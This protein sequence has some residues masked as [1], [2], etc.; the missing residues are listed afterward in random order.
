MVAQ[1]MPVDHRAMP[2]APPVSFVPTGPRRPVP[3][4]PWRFAPCL[5]VALVLPLLFFGVAHLAVQAVPRND[6][7]FEQACSASGFGGLLVFACVGVVAEL[8]AIVAF[9]VSFGRSNSARLASRIM[10]GIAVASLIPAGV[11]LH[12]G[13]RASYINSD[14]H[15]AHEC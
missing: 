6:C 15:Q 2:T 7:D 12:A 10:A 4:K 8:L 5:A 9:A 13:V 1:A 11:L 14:C 3:T